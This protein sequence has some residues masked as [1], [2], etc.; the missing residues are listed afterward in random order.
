MFTHEMLVA[1]GSNG[2]LASNMVADAETAIR[3]GER[4][5]TAAGDV[6]TFNKRFFADGKR[7]DVETARLSI[8]ITVQVMIQQA[9]AA[10]EANAPKVGVV[11]KIVGKLRQIVAEVTFSG[12]EVKISEVATAL[13]L[14]EVRIRRMAQNGTLS[15]GS[16]GHIAVDAK[17]AEQVRLRSGN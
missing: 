8:A 4:F 7:V 1:A 5:E 9:V 2:E 12:S 17:L 14:S 3:N 10:E 16:R 13:G 6:L 11:S 15:Y